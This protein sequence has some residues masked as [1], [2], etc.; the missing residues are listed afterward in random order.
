MVSVAFDYRIVCDRHF[1]NEVIRNKKYVSSTKPSIMQKLMYIND[2]SKGHSRTHNI[3]SKKI[4]QDILKENPNLCRSILRAFFYDSENQ[5]IENIGDEIERNIK[6][7]I[8]IFDEEPNRTLILTSEALVN[9]YKNNSHY[10][11]GVEIKAGI[12]AITIIDNYFESC[13]LK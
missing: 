2:K 4:F 5:E 6:I 7:A 10:I 11:N 3:M 8:D 13:C 9:A 12:E 1:F